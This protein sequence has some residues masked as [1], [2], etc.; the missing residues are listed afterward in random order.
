MIGDD[1]MSYRYLSDAKTL[2]REI[3]RGV[4][5]RQAVGLMKTV[6]VGNFRAYCLCGVPIFLKQYNPNFKL[7][8]YIGSVPLLSVSRCAPEKFGMRI[9]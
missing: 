1:P 2:V 3:L 9:E 7:K 5:K 6:A 4:F 8:F